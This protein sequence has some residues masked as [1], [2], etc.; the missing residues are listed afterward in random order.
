MF[1][2]VVADHEVK[3]VGIKTISLDIAE[4]PILRIFVVAE[5]FRVDI[6]RGDLC[7]LQHVERQEAGRPAAGLIDPEPGCRQFGPEE[8]VGGKQAF[9]RVA[10]R[11]IVEQ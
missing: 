7:A 4:D 8:F 9:A 11:Q 6:D 2:D 1:D 3:T 10:G 5:L